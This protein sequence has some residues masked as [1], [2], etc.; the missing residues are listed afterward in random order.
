MVLKKTRNIRN[1]FSKLIEKTKIY[2]H[3]IEQFK[4]IPILWFLYR[5]M[6]KKIYKYRTFDEKNLKSFENDEIWCSSPEYF[7]DDHEKYLY[8]NKDK[9]F[10]NIKERFEDI[11]D[12]FFDFDTSALCD[13]IVKDIVKAMKISCFSDTIASSSMWHHYA[14]SKKGFAIE[15]S[16]HDIFKLLMN[17]NDCNTIL[18]P[19]IYGEEKY[20]ASEFFY[21]QLYNIIISNYKLNRPYIPID[22]IGFFK[23]FLHKSNNWEYENE[24][25]LFSTHRDNLK[26]FSNGYV[27]SLP[28]KAVFIGRD[29]S[30]IDKEKI[31]T[32]AN[33]KQIP[34]F[35]MDDINSQ[36]KS[37][38]YTFR[39]IS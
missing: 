24:W 7:N 15:Y 23:I 27:I 5:N 9:I 33:K 26:Q 31:I 10:S 22:R 2:P 39:T 14:S 4:M 12:K 19:V 18:F 28:P 20:N 6:P 11:D 17:N 38:D 36:N 16:S 30:K 29:T 8:I 25:R 32:I 3:S 13:F 34:I 1:K 21:T 37:Y 35:Q